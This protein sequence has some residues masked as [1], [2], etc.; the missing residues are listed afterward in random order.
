MLLSGD[1]DNGFF[2]LTV[3]SG[4]WK[5]KV[6]LVVIRDT[7]PKICS[8]A[9]KEKL[10]RNHVLALPVVI[11]RKNGA[12]Q[13]FQSPQHLQTH[14]VHCMKS[15]PAVACPP[16]RQLCGDVRGTQEVLE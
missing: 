3:D 4:H 5:L 12:I 15:C 9:R 7:P 8:Y 10:S 2:V 16:L 11:L 14:P 6:S 13:C 1:K